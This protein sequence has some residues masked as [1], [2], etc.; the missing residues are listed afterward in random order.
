MPQQQFIIGDI[1]GC[2]DELEELLDKAG[3]ADEDEIIAVGDLIDRGPYSP[4]VLDWFRSTPN[5]RSIMGN[6]ER[7]HIRA[8]HGDLDPSKSQVI[9]RQQIGED[10]YPA[11]VAYM[12]SLPRFLDLPEA[13]IVHGFFEPGV[14]VDQQRDNVIIGSLSGESYIQTRYGMPWYASYNGDKP[15][16]VGHHNYTLTREPLIHDDRVYG[17]DTGCCFGNALTG[18]LLPAFRIV[19]VPARTNHWTEVKRQYATG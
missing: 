2:Y 16:I 4:R 5:A 6:H 18:L 11:A 9:A 14:P 8:Y 7:K 3:L 17:I 13:L 15:L 19:S 12:A 10:A 1:H